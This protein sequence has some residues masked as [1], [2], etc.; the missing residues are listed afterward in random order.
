VIIDALCM[1]LVLKPQDYQ[2]VVLPNLQGDIVSDLA[3]GLVGGLG[4]APVGQHRRPDLD[5]RG[6]ARHGAGHRRQGRG[7]PD[8]PA[9]Q[10]P[11]DAPPHRACCARRR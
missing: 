4:F 3:A 10:R 2:M 6:G 1:N 7:Q 9:A 5:L 8:Q 11:D